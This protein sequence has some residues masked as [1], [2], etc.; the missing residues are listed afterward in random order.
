MTMLEMARHIGQCKV[1]RQLKKRFYIPNDARRHFY[2]WEARNRTSDSIR[3][4]MFIKFLPESY[5]HFLANGGI[6]MESLGFLSKL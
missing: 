6:E 4:T 1:K 2:L 5:D 3:E